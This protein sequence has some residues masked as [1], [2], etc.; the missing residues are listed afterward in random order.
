MI[1]LSR[2]VDVIPQEKSYILFNTI[3]GDILQFENNMIKKIGNQFLLQNLCEDDLQYLKDRDFFVEDTRVREQIRDIK[4]KLEDE[5][6]ISISFSEDCNLKC[7]YCYQIK[8]NKEDGLN[9]DKLEEIVMSYVKEIIPQIEQ[10][11]GILNIRYIGGGAIA[12]E[13]GNNEFDKEN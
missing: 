10:I 12:K 13:N 2:Y 3:N 9:S 8:W 11:D 4:E 7:T 1:Y 6:D 5:T